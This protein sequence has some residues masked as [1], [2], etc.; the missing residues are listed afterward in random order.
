[1]MDL[2]DFITAACPLC[3]RTAKFLFKQIIQS[4]AF[5]HGAGVVHRDI[6]DENILLELTTG[7]TKLIDFGSGAFLKETAYT[8]Y[9]GTVHTV[10]GRKE[11]GGFS[12]GNGN[13]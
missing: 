2:F 7:R 8:D 11:R 9:E 3:E 1:M 6:K 5:C 13:S 12:Q 4:I 10:D